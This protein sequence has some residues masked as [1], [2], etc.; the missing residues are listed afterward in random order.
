MLKKITTRNRGYWYIKK[1]L[2]SS[3]GNPL[4]ATQIEKYQIIDKL[5]HEYPIVRVCRVLNVNRRSY[6][7]WIAV[8]KPMANNFDQT[9]ADVILEEH[10]NNKRIYGTIRLKYAIQNKLGL[11]LNHKL[12]RRYKH[13]LNITTIKRTKKCGSL[14]SISEVKDT[15]CAICGSI[16]QEKETKNLYFALSKFQDL[17]KGIH[18]IPETAL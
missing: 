9:I 8:G 5:K 16:T 18:L 13:I 6:Y 15:K 1:I 12:I 7:K 14:L 3:D 2:C 17:P 11:V 10:E 4:S